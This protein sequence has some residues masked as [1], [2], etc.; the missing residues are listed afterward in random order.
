[1]YIVQ[2]KWT[3]QVG[4]P[5]VCVV[6]TEGVGQH[7]LRFAGKQQFL[8]KD[9]VCWGWYSLYTAKERETS[10]SE[11]VI[12]VSR[13][14]TAFACEFSASMGAMRQ[15]A[16]LGALDV[17]QLCVSRGFEWCSD[18]GY[19]DGVF[20]AA[21]ANGHDDVMLFLI[22]DQCFLDNMAYKALMLAVQSERPAALAA[23]H[24]FFFMN[25]R[26]PTMRPPPCH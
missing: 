16:A 6:C 22:E 21:A 24:D 7:I 15:A 9:L 3:P 19:G 26:T 1:M 2:A 4:V 10:T 13:A 18:G 14:I 5:A 17:L 20:A 11:V 12:S 8:H 23:L 25:Y